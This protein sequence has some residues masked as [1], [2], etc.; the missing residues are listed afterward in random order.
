MSK[1]VVTLPDIRWKRR[2]IKTTQLLAQVLARQEALDRKAHEAWFVDDKGFVTEA[3]AS[4]AWIVDAKGNLVTRPVKGNVI[5]KGVTMNALQA[6]CRKEK[7]KIIYRTFTLREAYKAKEAFMSSAVALF[8]PVV[9][10]DGRKIGDGKPGKMV[11]KLYDLYMS[12]A[13]LPATKQQHWTA[14]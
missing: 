12:Y 8:V 11:S 6:L 14:Q 13:S 3:S 10:I 5:L 4:N 7:I 2:D 1:K 9:E